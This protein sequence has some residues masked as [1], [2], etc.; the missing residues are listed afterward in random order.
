MDYISSATIYRA[1]ASFYSTMTIIPDGGD[2][3][4]EAEADGSWVSIHTV[5]S[6]AAEVIEFGRLGARV[7]VTPVASAGVVIV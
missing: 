2:V 1:A 3:T 4:V 7:R 5:T 6:G